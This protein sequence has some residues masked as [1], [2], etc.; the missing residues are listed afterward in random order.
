ML[1]HFDALQAASG[2]GDTSYLLNLVRKSPA[3]READRLAARYIDKAL[4]AL[5]TLPPI[6][7][8]RSFIELSRFIANRSY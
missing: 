1:K 5:H 8:K 4:T 7:A 2:C 3:M 6:P